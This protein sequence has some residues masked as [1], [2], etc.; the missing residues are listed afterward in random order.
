MHN[1][2]NTLFLLSGGKDS[3]AALLHLNWHNSV[4]FTIL[5]VDTGKMHED[6]KETIRNVLVQIAFMGKVVWLE[7][8]RDGNWLEYGLPTDVLPVDSSVEG[9]RHNTGRQIKLQS[10]FSCCY[11]NIMLPIQ[12]YA[13][14]IGSNCI[15]RGNKKS[16]TLRDEYA[17]GAILD[18]I[19]Y[20]NPIEDWN[21]EKVRL[22]LRENLDNYSAHLDLEHS[23]IDCIDCTAYIDERYDYFTGY[24]PYMPEQEEVIANLKLIKDIIDND[25]D[26]LHHILGEFNG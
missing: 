11:R 19:T 13:R 22:Y 12:H 8:D 16:D 14:A 17:G 9:L 6:V 10:K 25:T 26:T 1:Y 18:G 23:S 4:D 5:I 3:L 2:K 21:D 24:L 20:L 7:S 15:I